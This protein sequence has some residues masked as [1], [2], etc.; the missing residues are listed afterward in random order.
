MAKSP[1]EMA[2]AMIANLKEKTGKTLEQWKKIVAKTKLEK[3]GQIVKH[4]K[5]EHAV[6]HGFANLIAHEFLNKAKPGQTDDLVDSQY[7]GPKSHL[8]PIYEAIIKAVAKFGKDIEKGTCL[9]HD[10]YVTKAKAEQNIHHS[11]GKCLVS[12]FFSVFL[13]E[14]GGHSTCSN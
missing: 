5:G 14:E 8:R 6:T 9:I 7:G 1:E 13:D 3:H 12:R 11:R 10:N 2:A 4:L